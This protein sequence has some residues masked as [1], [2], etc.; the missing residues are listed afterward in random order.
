MQGF[1]DIA[2]KLR[3][4][5]VHLSVGHRGQGSGIIASPD[6]MIVTN[7]HVATLGRVDVQFWDG[8]ALS[9]RAPVE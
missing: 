1:G 3:R 5:T 6:G 7:A 8:T 9:G 2:E 4:S